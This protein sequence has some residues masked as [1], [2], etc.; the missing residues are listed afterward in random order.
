[1]G[2]LTKGFTK[3]IKNIKAVT[4]IK[5]RDYLSER[6]ISE[7]RKVILARTIAGQGVSET[8]GSIGRLKPLSKKYISYR[9]RYKSSLASYTSPSKSNLTFS[10][11][12]LSSLTQKRV[13]PGNWQLFFKGNHGTGI[14]NARLAR[15]VSR[16]RPF[17]NLGRT[18]LRALNEFYKKEFVKLVKR[19]F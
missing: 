12:L 8:G 17:L 2:E 7:A 9:Q 14:S 15:Y 4:D 16:D 5:T 19:N 3:F 11:E 10:G 1:M 6:F 13:R 18:E